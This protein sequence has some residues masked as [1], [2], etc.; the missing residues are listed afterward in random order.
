MI[1]PKNTIIVTIHD[2]THDNYFPPCELQRS[3]KSRGALAEVV[4]PFGEYPSS[5]TWKANFLH[6]L[7][8]L[9]EKKGLSFLIVFVFFLKGWKVYQ[10]VNYIYSD[11]DR[12]LAYDQ[13]SAFAAKKASKGKLT[14]TLLNHYGGDPYMIY[15]Y[16]YGIENKRIGFRLIQRLLTSF[17]DNSVRPLS[18]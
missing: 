5:Q 11:Y 13:I 3:L 15:L 4:T 18:V 14:I 17:L 9:S 6:V 7:A 10:P 1:Q 16:K 2:P 8:Q 12:I